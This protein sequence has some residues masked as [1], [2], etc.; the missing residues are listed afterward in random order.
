MDDTWHITNHYNLDGPLSVARYKHNRIIVGY[1]DQPKQATHPA[2]T[3]QQTLWEVR[4]RAAGAQHLD[5]ENNARPVVAVY[6]SHFSHKK[7]QLVVDINP[8]FLAST[9][10][11]KILVGAVSPASVQCIDI[12]G[13]TCLTIKPNIE[14]CPDDVQVCLNGMCCNNR[15][16]IYVA[17]SVNGSSKLHVNQYDLQGHCT[18]SFKCDITFPITGFSL[19]E[20]G[21]LVVAEQHRLKLFQKKT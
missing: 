8:N 11:G 19:T 14:G 4:E 13:K 6:D 17:L 9:S 5:K 18:G 7:C 1:K 2:Y 3:Q 16:I 10:E 20:D 12:N 21:K 15:D